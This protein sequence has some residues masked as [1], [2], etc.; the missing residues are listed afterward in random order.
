[1]PTKASLRLS[2]DRPPQRQSPGRWPEAGSHH[3]NL[4][5]RADHS[6]RPAALSGPPSL[7]GPPERSR[8][9]SS[10]TTAFRH[11][12]IFSSPRLWDTEIYT[13][14]ISCANVCR[15]RDFPRR[16]SIDKHR[17]FTALNS[18]QLWQFDCTWEGSLAVQKGPLEQGRS[19]KWTGKI[20][21]PP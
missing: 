1:M 14:L 15:Y 2:P 8:D 5:S 7:R 6:P 20:S 19:R 21:W 11:P 3:N 17:V 13:E 4:Q 18:Q 12:A 9:C 16:F 10:A